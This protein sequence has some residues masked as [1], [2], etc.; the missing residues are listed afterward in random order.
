MSKTTHMWHN[1]HH[2]RLNTG[3]QTIAQGPPVGHSERRIDP[4]RVTRYTFRVALFFLT[5][6]P[7]IWDLAHADDSTFLDTFERYV[8]FH[9][10]YLPRVTKRSTASIS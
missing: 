6:A 10:W 5:N 1:D 7:E 2:F 3:A 9:A 8:V 4:L